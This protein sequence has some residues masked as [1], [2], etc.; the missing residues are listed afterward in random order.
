[1]ED[2]NKNISN[3][4]EEQKDRHEEIL[5]SLGLE[6]FEEMVLFGAAIE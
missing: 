2:D 3:K 6:P 5:E 4:E 1:M